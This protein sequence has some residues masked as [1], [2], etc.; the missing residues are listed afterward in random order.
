MDCPRAIQLAQ[1]YNQAHRCP[2]S[3]ASCLAHVQ[4]F[5]CFTKGTAGPRL[6]WIGCERPK[7]VPPRSIFSVDRV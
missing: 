7:G 6:I 3:S 4:G 5:K 2:Y 1:A